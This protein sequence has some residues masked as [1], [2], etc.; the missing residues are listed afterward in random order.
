MT[1]TGGGRPL[2]RAAL[3][4]ATGSLGRHLARELLGRGIE[5]R[6]ISRSREHL[7]RDF[8]GM[9]VDLHPADL[10]QPAAACRV[11][12]GCDVLFHCVGLPLAA[13]ETH[14]RL[15]RSTAEAMRVSGA[16]AVA[17]SSYW[18]FGPVGS[19]R[20]AEDD[21][22][23]PGCVPCEVR[24]RMED[25]LLGA[26]AAVAIFPDFYGPMATLSILNDGLAALVAGRKVRWP[27]DPDAPREFIFLPD[28]ARL[29]CDLAAHPGSEGRRWNVPG[30]EAL[31]PRELLEEAGNIAGQKA[32]VSAL[33]GWMVRLA[34]L[35]RSDARELTS[36]LPLYESPIGLD[37]SRLRGLL[38]D[39]ELTP[40]REGIRAT[41]DWLGEG[42]AT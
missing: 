38:G 37:A 7:E 11:A 22:P 26:G 13:Y 28:A 17:A 31:S 21:A 30:G 10:A 25:V 24:R 19:T 42:D 35:V 20:L 34:A 33:R 39:L 5:V 2:R 8:G 16:R 23:V 41:L 15:A 12:E 32:R 9:D 27:G 40:Y 6:A 4:G 14:V 3:F 29:A 1:D 36:I 18:S